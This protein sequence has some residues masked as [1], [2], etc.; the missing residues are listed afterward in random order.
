M[1][2]M[3]DYSHQVLTDA[4]ERDVARMAEHNRQVRLALSGR[5]SWWRRLIARLRRRMPAATDAKPPV[6]DQ[7]HG[8]GVSEEPVF[9][10]VLTRT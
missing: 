10:E 2:L 9:E 7:G 8:P 3:N 6:E 5:V 1:S 4:R